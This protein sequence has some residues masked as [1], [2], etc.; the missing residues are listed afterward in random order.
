MECLASKRPS[1]ALVLSMVTLLL[2]ITSTAGA[3][4]GK[5]LVKK[6][7]I[8]KG[9]VTAR[10]LAG[11]AVKAKAIAPRAVTSKKLANDAIVER[12]LAPFSVGAFALG[13]TTTVS[14]PIPDNDALPAPGNT[15]WTTS[16]AVVAVCPSGS[17]LLGGGVSIA[18]GSTAHQAAVETTA[19]N[20]D[21]WQGA[22]S[23]N[24]G[25]SAPGTVYAICLL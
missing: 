17:I 22:I 12:T 20:G 24:T 23:T 6:G 3:L 9:A 13:D 19:P 1:P 8:A 5:D 21:R 25:G 18:D 4:P 14:A 7:D 10:A 15:E 11:G 2:A 16:P